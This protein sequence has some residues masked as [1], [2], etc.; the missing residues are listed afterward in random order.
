MIYF[1]FQTKQKFTVF[2]FQFTDWPDFGIPDPVKFLSFLYYCRESGV[3]EKK[4]KV[5]GIP[6]IHCSA[7][8]GRSGTFVL[9]DCA[10]KMVS[11]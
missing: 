7:G 11:E 6:V 1:L 8:V 5:W 2:H 9:V 3:M 4:E 10:L